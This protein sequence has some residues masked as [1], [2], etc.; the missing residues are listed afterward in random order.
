MRFYKLL[1]DSSVKDIDICDNPVVDAAVFT[2]TNVSY[3]LKGNYY[4]MTANLG[5]DRGIKGFANL[6]SSKWPQI[7]GPVKAAFVVPLLA[8]SSELITIFVEVSLDQQ[9][10]QLNIYRLSQ[11]CLNAS[12]GSAG[13]A[14]MCLKSCRLHE[15][16]VILSV[17]FMHF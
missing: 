5:N 10:C 13:C 1:F 9:F 12:V 16:S 6:I 3:I 11:K 14:S 8:N 7:K 15:D 17:P 4:W 2:D